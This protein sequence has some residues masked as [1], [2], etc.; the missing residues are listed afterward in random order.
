MLKEVSKWEIRFS[1]KETLITLG[2]RL[3]LT[4]GVTKFIVGI[5]G[6]IVQTENKTQTKSDSSEWFAV[7]NSFS[8]ELP[9]AGI[10]IR[11]GIDSMLVPLQ[12]SV[13]G[14]RSFWYAGF[15]F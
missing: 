4:E 14:V 6:G 11:A 2:N 15:T 8:L 5:N 3:Q 12:I 13:L 10:G 9:I 1:E 7:G